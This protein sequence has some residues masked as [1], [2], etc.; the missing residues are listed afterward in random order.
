MYDIKIGK[1]RAECQNETLIHI[2]HTTATTTTHYRHTLY[3][4]DGFIINIISVLFVVLATRIYHLSSP[5]QIKQPYRILCTYPSNNTKTRH[6][7]RSIIYI[8]LYISPETYT[9]VR[10]I[11]YILRNC[12]MFLLLLPPKPPSFGATMCGIK[13]QFQYHAYTQNRHFQH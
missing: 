4:C 1:Q 9:H 6:T 13:T 10:R 5:N 2:V 12:K 7:R 8:H 11:L 3:F